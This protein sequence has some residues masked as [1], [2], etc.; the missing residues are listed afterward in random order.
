M[1]MIQPSGG[2]IPVNLADVP[3]DLFHLIENFL[4]MYPDTALAVFREAMDNATD[5]GATRVN[6]V[7]GKT[8]D[9]KCFISFEDNG[10]GMDESGLRT[11]IKV[12]GSSKQ[13]NG[14]SIGFAG[15]GAKIYLAKD[16]NVQI[17]TQTCNGSESYETILSRAENSDG[18]KR[19]VVY[20]YNG[21]PDTFIK[22]TKNTRGTLYKIINLNFVD[23]LQIQNEIGEWC[24]KY[25]NEALLNGLKV[26]INGKNIK[27]WKPATI[28][29]KKF[30][31]KSQGKK[32]PSTV[33]ILKN[34][35]PHGKKAIQYN[36]GGHE[37]KDKD[38]KYAD[39]IKPEFKNKILVTIDANP[40][41]RYV[42]TNK[43]NFNNGA[44]KYYPQINDT[45][46]RELKKQG[47]IIDPK[48]S[49]SV[50]QSLE[51]AL[52]EVLEKDFPELLQ[53][54]FTG[55]KVGTKKPK[56]QT[57]C[58]GTP[59]GSPRGPSTGG[60]GGF[61]RKGFWPVFRVGDEY[62]LEGYLD[63][64]KQQLVINV[65]HYLF[66]QTQTDQGFQNYHTTKVVINVLLES[67]HQKFPMSLT[68]LMKKQTEFMI[69]VR[70]K[71]ITWKKF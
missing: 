38:Y 19:R 35:L 15:I 45:I 41:I 47:V 63:P 32:F 58:G 52:R 70:Q 12:G 4:G 5:I 11:Y 1:T 7:F 9:G 30:I 28:S 33:Y 22:S 65:G 14:Q 6:I 66:Q 69:K 26:T 56:K 39:Q 34:S 29:K 31:I 49:S 48:A 2:S 23:Y 40:L 60:C 64:G 42:T 8:K 61:S 54:L 27:A 17:L 25:Y 18:E 3:S 44:N 16:E 68:E 43:I 37:I 59:P 50:N 62:G 20:T 53:D 57:K 24:I 51:K 10:S 46:F 71:G 21:T 67:Y 55:P 13:K 36:I